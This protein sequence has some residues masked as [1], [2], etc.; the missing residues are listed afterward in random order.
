M[1]TQLDILALEPF[2]GGAR[3]AMLEC[4]IKHSRH[5]W[6]VL[7]LPPRR[8]E[9]R[10][11]AAAHWFAEQL[12]LHWVGKIDV[13]FASEALNLADLFRLAPPLA[14][15]PSV[16]Y[17][18][19]NQ[20][21]P[22][23]IEEDFAA[24]AAAAPSILA[25]L[26]TAVAASEMWFNSNFHIQTFLSRAQSFIER[27]SQTFSRNPIDELTQKARLM[28][29]PTDVYLP[30]EILKRNPLKHD[31]RT[32]F[33]NLHQADCDLIDQALAALDQRG[34]EFQLMTLGPDNALSPPWKRT[35]IA[36]DNQIAAVEAMLQCGLIVSGQVDP[37]WDH[38]LAMALAAGCWPIAPD[39][40]VYPELILKPYDERC[41]YDQTPEG[42]VALLQDFWELQLPEGH[43]E[44]M[45]SCLR[46]VHPVTAT[47]AIDDRLSELAAT[48]T[49]STS[50]PPGPVLG[51]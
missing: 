39:A 47:K 30:Q 14:A 45:R 11:A 4:L 46:K 34:E 33:I 2:Y 50:P 10:L 19:S 38:H 6:T 37:M 43:R 26:S 8:I 29:P 5:K 17:F 35:K 40:G 28:A 9:R 41:L 13:L 24:A 3:K 22:P 42:L 12:S 32:I 48:A 16:V 15:K 31:N 27:H 21:P 18:H 25:N 49:V 1:P 23:G 20:L 44:A 7:K 51:F 36:E